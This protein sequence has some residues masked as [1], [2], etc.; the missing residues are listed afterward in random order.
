[1]PYPNLTS[2]GIPDEAIDFVIKKIGQV[3]DLEAKT[4]SGSSIV[5][6]PLEDSFWWEFESE[7]L[8]S[9]AI[10]GAITTPYNI[11]DSAYQYFLDPDM[12]KN[13]FHLMVALYRK[14]HISIQPFYDSSKPAITFDCLRYLAQFITYIPDRVIVW[15][16]H[17]CLS[18]LTDKARVELIM[19]NITKLLWDIGKALCGLHQLGVAHGDCRLDNVG[20]SHGDFVLFD[21]GSSKQNSSVCGDLD[22]L[23]GSI[24]FHLGN[25][26]WSIME[27]LVPETCD[28]LMFLSSILE[29]RNC[30]QK[31][32]DTLVIINN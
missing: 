23:R 3:Y 13:I 29:N 27:I 4:S 22:Q 25:D 26:K 10:Y 30:T 2:E 20:I 19:K 31:R 16:R 14:R 24:K 17:L 28:S 6:L 18:E 8:L 32:L 1:M 15:R 7:E 5:F 9:K 12:A 21:F 11:Y